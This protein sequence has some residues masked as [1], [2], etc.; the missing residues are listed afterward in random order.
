MTYHEKSVFLTHLTLQSCS[1]EENTGP[2]N[3]SET[4]D[5]ATLYIL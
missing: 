3:H 1:E 2:H 5:K 4:P